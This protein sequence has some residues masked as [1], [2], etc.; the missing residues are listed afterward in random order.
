MT[1]HLIPE[2]TMNSV[3]PQR[4]ALRRRLMPLATATLALCA[5]FSLMAPAPV[6]AQWIVNDPPALIQS[7][8]ADIA[9]GLEYIETAGRWTQT[10]SHYTATLNN[11]LQKLQNWSQIIANPIMPATPTL[12]T[13]PDDWNIAERCGGGSV[14]SITGIMA[15]AG[16]SPGGDIGAQQRTICSYIQALENRKYNET[17]KVVQQSLPLMQQTLGTLRNIRRLF[18]NE[19]ALAETTAN[20]TASQLQIDANFKTWENQMRIYDQQIV[21][22]QSQQRALAQRALKGETNPIGSVIKAAALKTALD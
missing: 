22:L 3:A 10:A 12:T 14:F 4:P 6:Q 20:A 7:V 17:V 5:S 16:I 13:I 2:A 19:G 9:T 1:T 21:A 15:M 8:K 18:D 11:W